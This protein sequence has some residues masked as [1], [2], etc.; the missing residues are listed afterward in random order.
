[1]SLYQ[2]AFTIF[3][4]QY[5]MYACSGII[6]SGSLGGAASMFALTHGHGFFDMLQVVVLVATCMGYNATVLSNLERDTVFKWLIVSLITGVVV[7]LINLF[8]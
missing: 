4:S 7:I 8:R 6:A 1:M 3:K 5:L 2:R